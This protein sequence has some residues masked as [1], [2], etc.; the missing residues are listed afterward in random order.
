MKYTV[1]TVS[2]LAVLMMGFVLEGCGGAPGSV[3]DDLLNNPSKKCRN[4]D[5][6]VL[7]YGEP[8]TGWPNHTPPSSIQDL[9]WNRDTRFLGLFGTNWGQED[10]L[11]WSTIKYALMDEPLL[12]DSNT[13]PGD[14]ESKWQFLQDKLNAFKAEHPHVLVWVNFSEQEIRWWQQGHRINGNWDIVS[15]DDY[16]GPRQWSTIK[17]RLDFIAA[18][19]NPNQKMGLVPDGFYGG[20]S[21]N[22]QQD[23][24]TMQGLYQQ[25]ALDHNDIVVVMAPFLWNDFGDG[26]VYKGLNSNPAAIQQIAAFKTAYP[27][28]SN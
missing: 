12:N 23:I 19:K 3:P 22:S 28:C 16:L 7:N 2:T 14:I 26:N 27:K 11:D 9:M 13:P 1:T 8:L 17:S 10:S 18:N 4:F 5:M 15:M 20:D 6:S 21:W 24:V 25:W